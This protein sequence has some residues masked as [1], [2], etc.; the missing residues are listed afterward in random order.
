MLN[1]SLIAGPKAKDRSRW[2]MLMHRPLFPDNC[3]STHLRRGRVAITAATATSAT[4]TTTTTAAAAASTTATT[5][6]ARA[7]TAAAAR[8]AAA[9]A[10]RVATDRA[11]AARAATDRPVARSSSRGSYPGYTRAHKPYPP[12]CYPAT[13]DG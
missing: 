9:A 7:A 13:G 5:A 12:C 10:I 1:T 8:A 4:T 11:A 2:H 3:I 6:A